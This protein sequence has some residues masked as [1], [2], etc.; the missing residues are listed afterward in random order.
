VFLSNELLDAFPVKLVEM[1]MNSWRF[2]SRS[3]Q[4]L[5][6]EREETFRR[7][8]LVEEKNP[9]VQSQGLFKGFPGTFQRYR[10]EVNLESKMAP[11]GQRETLRGFCADIDYGIRQ[12]TIQ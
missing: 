8:H 5:L 9:A 11:E 6:K 10:T 7:T 12:W 4:T 2:M 1:D 3:F